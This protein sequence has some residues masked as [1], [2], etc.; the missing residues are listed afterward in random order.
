MDGLEWEINEERPGAVCLDETHC[1]IGNVVGGFRVNRVFRRWY[2]AG[3][4]IELVGSDQS[5][6]KSES[7]GRKLGIAQMPFTGEKV[8]IARIPQSLRDRDLLR[9]Q[10]ILKRC[11]VQF[12]GAFSTEKIGEVNTS[13][14]FAGHDAGARG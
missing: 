4:I 5:R 7:I 9:S 10:M 8:G 11:G 1:L 6:A 3:W 14:V 13:R 2:I 12:A